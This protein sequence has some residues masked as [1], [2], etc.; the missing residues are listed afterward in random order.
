[1]FHRRQ[2][3]TYMEANVDCV[4]CGKIFTSVASLNRHKNIAKHTTRETGIRKR[5]APVV[6][7][8][9]PAKKTEN[10]AKNNK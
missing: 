9:Q 7:T 5:S 8:N 3:T 6:E 4:V 10:K 2:K 1:M